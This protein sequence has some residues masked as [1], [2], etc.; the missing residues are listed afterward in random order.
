MLELKVLSL[1]HSNTPYSRYA[2]CSSLICCSDKPM[3]K[4][5]SEEKGVFGLHFKV[6]VH[7]SR[8]LG[9]N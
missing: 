9:R 2:I 1:N 5:N 8:N 3:A 6:T 7:Q 4:G